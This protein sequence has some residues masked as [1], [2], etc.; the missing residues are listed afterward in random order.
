MRSPHLLQTLS[1]LS[2]LRN[3]RVMFVALQQPSF[4]VTF[5]RRPLVHFFKIRIHFSPP[6]LYFL[7]HLSTSP[8]L[9]SDEVV[10]A[11]V[12][13][14]SDASVMVFMKTPATA[15]HVCCQVMRCCRCQARIFPGQ[16]KE[17]AY[18]CGPCECSRGSVTSTPRGVMG[19]TCHA[20]PRALA[21]T[22]TH[23]RARTS[24]YH[25]GLT[26]VC[27]IANIHTIPRFL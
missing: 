27:A 3:L 8:F 9:S 7:T 1:L 25:A 4:F 11:C 6:E 16:A 21:H 17:S 19:C 5:P 2:P 22:H 26:R 10:F 18:I 24:Y 20:P 14:L 23:T 12:R 13:P 15:C